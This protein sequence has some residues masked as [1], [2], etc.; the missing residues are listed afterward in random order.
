MPYSPFTPQHLVTFE[1]VSLKE[2]TSEQW[3]ST[4]I[5][6]TTAFVPTL[7][8]RSW[9]FV[10]NVIFI[11][12]QQENER[13]ERDLIQAEKW[14]KLSSN[15]NRKSTITHL[16]VFVTR[17]KSKQYPSD[18]YY[19]LPISAAEHNILKFKFLV[20]LKRISG[21]QISPIFIFLLNV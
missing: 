20:T 15:Y 18:F 2:V 14:V 11:K 5:P 1:R 13:F 21:S 6:E 17:F 19:Y 9:G 10:L 12:S 3:G 7:T 16:E 8:P 4:P